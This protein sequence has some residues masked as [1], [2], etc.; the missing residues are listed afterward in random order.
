MSCTSSLISQN[1]ADS[2]TIQSQAAFHSSETNGTIVTNGTSDTAGTSSNRS[3]AENEI[4]N[5]SSLEKPA[6]NLTAQAYV[7]AFYMDEVESFKSRNT[8]SEDITNKSIWFPALNGDDPKI[9]KGWLDMIGRKDN[10]SDYIKEFLKD[11]DR[12]PHAVGCY[13]SHWHLIRMMAQRDP[14]HR[15]DLLFIFEDDA[16][17]V[18]RLMERTMKIAASLPEDW[19]M[20]FL[21]G[22]PFTFFKKVTDPTFNRME[23]QHLRT[24]SLDARAPLLRKYA[25]TGNLSHGESPLAPDGS[26]QLSLD[27]AFWQTKYTTNLEAYVVNTKRINHIL[28]IISPGPRSRRA[29][30]IV[31]A[32]AMTSGRIKAYMPTMTFCTQGRGQIVHEPFPWKGYL[33][34]LPVNYTSLYGDAVYHWDELYFPECPG[35]Y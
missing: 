4:R 34:Y 32:E 21:G 15:P 25:C 12:G 5:S 3:A 23:V 24:L 6:T 9:M 13:L 35:M 17:C 26:R 30:D 7:I 14:T 29:I 16:A 10:A 19:D 11:P 8:A 22:K 2:S 28:N 31:Y 1:Y 20:L 33:G 27:Q 18:S